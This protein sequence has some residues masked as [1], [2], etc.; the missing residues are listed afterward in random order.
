MSTRQFSSGRGAL[1]DRRGR[2]YSFSDVVHRLSRR[3]RLCSATQ[4]VNN[5]VAMPSLNKQ[6]SLADWL[7]CYFGFG[8]G[9]NRAPV[10][11]T[12]IGQHFDRSRNPNTDTHPQVTTSNVSFYTDCA[13]CSLQNQV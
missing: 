13:P 5:V 12:N 11:L 9:T 3:S 10:R 4:T 7:G 8:S 6:F 2:L 1:W